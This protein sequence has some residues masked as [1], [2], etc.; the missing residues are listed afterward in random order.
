PDLVLRASA[1]R[2]GRQVRVTAELTNRATH[3]VALNGWL[4]IELPPGWQPVSLPEGCVS[5]NPV[6]CQLGDLGKGQSVGLGL[7]LSGEGDGRVLFRAGASNG[8]FPAGDTRASVTPAR[9]GAQAARREEGGS[10][11]GGG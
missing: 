1:A 9:A 7:M 6:R 5:G 4:N 11:G 3:R 8:D 10:G 2:A